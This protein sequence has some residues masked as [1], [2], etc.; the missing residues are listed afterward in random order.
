MLLLP[1]IICVWSVSARSFSSNG[2]ST[3]LE[4]RRKI[5]DAEDEMRVG[6]DIVLTRLEETVNSILM[7]LKHD[8]IEAARVNN[9]PFLPHIHFFKAKKLMEQNK[10]FQ[11]IRSMPKGQ[12]AVHC[13]SKIDIQHCSFNLCFLL[14]SH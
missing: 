12:C 1:L 10:V 4:E 11:I 7:K 6:G 14:S 2:N 9:K 8:E 3:Y 13:F 5:L